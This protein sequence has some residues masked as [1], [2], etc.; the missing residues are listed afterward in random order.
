MPVDIAHTI[1]DMDTKQSE[2]LILR[3]TPG[4][5]L[6]LVKEAHRRRLDGRSKRGAVAEVVREAL[7]HAKG[8]ADK[9]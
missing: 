6:W 3:V 1:A 4:I 9:P 2:L 7:E 5:K 8:Q